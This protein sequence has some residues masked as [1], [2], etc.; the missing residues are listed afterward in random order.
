MTD[1]T[2]PP[3]KDDYGAQIALSKSDLE[4]YVV[5]RYKRSILE[6]VELS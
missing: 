1:I 6:K 2:Q 4:N 3:T 5:K